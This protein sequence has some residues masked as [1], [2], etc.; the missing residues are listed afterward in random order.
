MGRTLT[1]A[2]A[3][4][5]L[6]ACSSTPAHAGA[7]RDA[8][9]ASVAGEPEP[10]AEQ[11]EPV[12]EQREPVAEESA[13]ALGAL[14]G[15]Y[16]FAGGKAEREALEAA[17]D[18][19]IADMNPLVRMIARRRLLAANEIAG[20]LT[21]RADGREVTVA[22]N[23]RAYTAVVGGPAVEVTGITGDR[24]ALTHRL[25]G[26]KLVQRFD[27]T[28]GDRRNVLVLR[29][30]RIRLHVRVESDQLPRPLSY[31]LTFERA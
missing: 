14:A 27:G 2:T 15:A 7:D 5:A 31:T 12:A 8:G 26:R 19:V 20:K 1:T 25:E 30:A 13:E 21:I 9:V 28:R 18:D 17:V 11:R 3:L 4:V 10:V 23:E 22:F 16:A 29:S 6:L 24:L